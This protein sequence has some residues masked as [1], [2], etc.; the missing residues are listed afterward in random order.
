MLWI[1]PIPPSQAN[2]LPSA[3]KSKAILQRIIIRS[4]T[5]KEESFLGSYSEGGNL[6]VLNVA[7]MRA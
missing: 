7:V 2:S 3:W 1:A 6:S 5:I 4:G